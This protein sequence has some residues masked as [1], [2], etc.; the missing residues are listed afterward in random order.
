MSYFA[1][2]PDGRLVHV[3]HAANSNEAFTAV[4]QRFGKPDWVQNSCPSGRYAD[5][6]LDLL[7][8]PS[9]YTL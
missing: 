4:T 3:R 8:E 7:N 9:R 5:E 6:E 1:Q 2:L